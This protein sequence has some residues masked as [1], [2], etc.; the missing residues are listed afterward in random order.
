[1]T[2]AEKDPNAPS[3]TRSYVNLADSRLGASALEASDEFF[4]AK[5]R[6]L[7][8]APAQFY[9]GR[10]DDHGKWM[11]GWETRRRRG[12]GH[13]W[14]V[15]QLARAGTIAGLEL[16]TSHFTGNFP[17]AASVDACFVA[18]GAPAEDT[19]WAP[20]LGS[21]SLRGNHRHY[22]EVST[23]PVVSH[24]RVNLY[25]DG[26]LARLRAYGRPAFE[27]AERDGEGLVDLAAALNGG[28]VV[29]ANNEH[30][31]P[32]SVL[33]L[34]GRGLNMGDG[35]ET[36]RRREP[37]NDWCLIA[38]ARAGVIERVEVD[39]AYFRGN[40]PDRC[41]IQAAFVDGGTPESLVP[42]AM[43]WCE[44]LPEQKLQADHVHVFRSE[45]RPHA[46]ISHV[47]F[48]MI[49]DGGVSRL[50]LWGRPG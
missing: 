32:A 34:P 1:M 47:R 5:E 7:E 4:A 38:L 6:M 48:N 19:A 9:P 43:F 25:P 20:L 44:L 28:S 40:F 46:P 27:R 24:L 42:Q 45:L 15:V 37:G 26:G 29:A 3:F 12:V 41:S 8:P 35:W 2:V 13:D 49:P 31:G 18:T 33:L 16:D 30:F 22:F 11:D 23:G 50:R 21:V 14:C 39:T 10:Y 17:P 36:R